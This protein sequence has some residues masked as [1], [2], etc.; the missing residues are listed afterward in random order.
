MTARGAAVGKRKTSQATIRCKCGVLDRSVQWVLQPCGCV[1]EITCDKCTDGVSRGT[2]TVAAP[3][4][5]QHSCGKVAPVT[6]WHVTRQPH[7]ERKEK[8]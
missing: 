8:R 6:K 1:L 4:R 2:L 3:G 7:I 5:L